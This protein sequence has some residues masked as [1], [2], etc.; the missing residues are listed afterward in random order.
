MTNSPASREKAR[1]AALEFYGVLDSEPQAEFDVL[2]ETAAAICGTP[3]A[4]VSFHG[5]KTAWFKAS[6]G[7]D[8]LGVARADNSL[9]N[10]AMRL[11]DVL[12]VEDACYDARFR[13]FEPVKG[14]PYYRFYAGC[15]ILT[16]EG[17]ALGTV[18]AIDYVPRTIGVQ[19]VDGL[20]SVAKLA[21]TLLEKRQAFHESGAG[22]K[23]PRRGTANK[24]NL[25]LL[26]SKALNPM[27]SPFLQEIHAMR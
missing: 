13:D 17:L 14:P 19:Q 16:K 7:L 20:R 10:A 23:H 22:I 3:L 6:V 2:A 18:V 11:G 26:K 15:P 12:V 1:L 9:C 27:L 4:I 25:D 5:E 8:R 21:M 24:K